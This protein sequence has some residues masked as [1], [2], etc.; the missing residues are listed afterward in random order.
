MYVTKS[1]RVELTMVTLAKN[2][3]VFSVFLVQRVW[4]VP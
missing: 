1:I 3:A 4:F 2:V